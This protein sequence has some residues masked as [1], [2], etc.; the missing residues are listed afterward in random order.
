MNVLCVPVG[1]DPDGGPAAYE[2]KTSVSANLTT[3]ITQV[4]TYSWNVMVVTHE[5][6][7]NIASPHTCLFL[8]W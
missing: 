8:E 4:P 2:Y 7:H 5:F 3:P 1:T 6:G